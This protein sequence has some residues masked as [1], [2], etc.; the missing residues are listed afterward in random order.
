MVEDDG[1]ELP[2]RMDEAPDGQPISLVLAIQTGRSAYHEFSRMQGLNS[3]LQPLFALG[4][5]R[6]ALVE[7][8]SSPQLVRNFTRDETL[9]RDDLRNLQRGDDGASILDVVK[10]SI[11]SSTNRGNDCGCCY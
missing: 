6:V 11:C 10:L 7:F 8:D 4:A 1:A 9:I 5:A 3:M 2:V